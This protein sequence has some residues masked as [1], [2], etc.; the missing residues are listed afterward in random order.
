MSF[1]A[2]RDIITDVNE[3]VHLLHEFVWRISL[4]T[5]FSID[6]SRNAKNL[7]LAFY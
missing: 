4:E 3:N 6:F 7:T 2:I 1:N 5:K